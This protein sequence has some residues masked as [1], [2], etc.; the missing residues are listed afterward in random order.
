MKLTT[1]DPGKGKY[2]LCGDIIGNTLHRTVSTRHFMRLVDG[3]GIQENAFVEAVSKG[4][5]KVEMYVK[6]TKDTWTSPVQAWLD[7]GK[8]A[9]Y[10]FGKQR[11]LSLK[12]MERR[13]KP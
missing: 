8:V 10:G 13:Q 5:T 3:Y 12:Y 1:W 6:E 2:V 11:F 7:H 4:V 9:D